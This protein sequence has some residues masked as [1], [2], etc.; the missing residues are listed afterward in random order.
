MNTSQSKIYKE[1]IFFKDSLTRVSTNSIGVDENTIGKSG[2]IRPVLTTLP[3]K[4][5]MIFLL[6]LFLFT[7]CSKD[8]Y[9]PAGQDVSLNAGALKAGAIMYYISPNGNNSS[10][11]DITHPWQTLSY[12]C[13]HVTNSGDIIH[14]KAGTY[15]ETAQSVLAVGVSIEGEGSNVSIIKANYAATSLIFA[16]S[17]V[18]NTN[19]NQSISYIT[20]D[21]NYGSSPVANIGIRVMLRGNVKIYHCDIKNFT[22]M[23][24]YLDGDC[25]YD[26][27]EPVYN[28]GNE[29]YSCT[30]E[31]CAGYPGVN[32]TRGAFEMGGQKD[33]LIHD[34][35]WTLTTRGVGVGGDGECIKAVASWF[36][37]VKI[38]N[39][40]FVKIPKISSNTDFVME[41]WKSRGG[42][43]IY[44]NRIYGRCDICVTSM[45]SPYTYGLSFHDNIVGWDTPQSTVQ[46]GLHMESEM[47]T[48]LVYNN[49]FQNLSGCIYETTGESGVGHTSNNVTIYNNILSNIT[50]AYGSAIEIETDGTASTIRNFHV[51]N[52]VIYTTSA[53][54][55]QGIVLPM[56]GT[57]TGFKIQNNVIQ[58]FSDVPIK[59]P[60]GSTTTCSDFTITNNMFTANANGNAANWSGK[61]FTNKTESNNHP[62]ENPLFVSAP[63]NFKLQSGSPCIDAG[64]SVGL[65]YNGSAPDIGTFETTSGGSNQPPAITEP[66]ASI[67]QSPVINEQFFRMSSDPLKG[68]LI[69]TALA[70]DPNAGQRLTYSIIG[71]NSSDAFTINSSN[72]EIIFNNKQ[73]FD[74]IRDGIYFLTVKVLDN[75]TPAL[76]S[77]ATITIKKQ[78]KTS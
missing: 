50:S 16:G 39:N 59:L 32:D 42:L 52:N 2:P 17:G 61:T 21:G 73:A 34:N 4:I 14:V 48:A 26:S 28:T 47:E 55:Y 40:T 20:L 13:A 24:I 41:I 68:T 49:S 51:L 19:G 66:K 35:T 8:E 72:G 10:N 15:Y 38:Y 7:S 67:N 23:G 22:S 57:V 58:G 3:I 69:G 75:G 54:C 62:G 74:K 6:G 5:L 31:N 53:N 29:V 46:K 43:E 36:K 11:G 1:M 18:S 9:T 64:V 37:G 56:T 70:S 71:E 76:S 44:N 25:D 45:V 33:L 78:N 30:F 77:Q 65:P 60:G 63:T 27:P 12:A